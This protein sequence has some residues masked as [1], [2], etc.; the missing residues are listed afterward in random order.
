M[1]SSLE[2]YS[3]Q[4]KNL[5][6][7]DSKLLD[8]GYRE[9]KFTKGIFYKKC[10]FGTSKLDFR[11]VGFLSRSEQVKEG[12]LFYYSPIQSTWQSRR[13]RKSERKLL[14]SNKIKYRHSS[15]E[16]F[17][18]KVHE[19][20]DGFCVFCNIDF[21]DEGLHCSKECERMCQN[22]PTEFCD[23]CFEPIS[24]Q[25]R[26]ENTI[27]HHISYFPEELIVV[28]KECHNVI[29]NSWEYPHL[30]PSQDETDKFYQKG[31]YK[32]EKPI[33]SSKKFQGSL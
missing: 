12:P 22:F 15:K 5:I 14:D 9:S 23:A 6:P 28:H 30:R 1:D 29:H 25:F 32:I 21:Q 26:H 10:R 4:E 2:N 8:L 33:S 16:K 27:E 11:N 20:G 18:E 19:E 3:K 24:F 17:L 31:K 13:E 7:V